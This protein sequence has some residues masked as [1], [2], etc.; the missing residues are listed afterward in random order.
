MLS[1]GII[2]LLVLWLLGNIT[3]RISHR[4][5][6]PWIFILL[7]ILGGTIISL[8]VISAT[9]ILNCNWKSLLIWSAIFEVGMAA[10][11]ALI[12]LY[13]RLSSKDILAETMAMNG[14][15]TIML[16]TI[17]QTIPLI[18]LIMKTIIFLSHALDR[19]LAS[20][21]GMPAW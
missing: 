8:S 21:H 3:H 5:K 19:F 12:F 2:F 13:K 10:C 11:S 17:L 9:G 4:D 7:G 16:I 18:P 15:S 1:V 20:I 6:D 14:R